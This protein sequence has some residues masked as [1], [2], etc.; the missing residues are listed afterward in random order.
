M[1]CVQL[2]PC[3]HT[4]CETC[5]PKWYFKAGKGQKKGTCITCRQV[6]AF[7]DVVRAPAAK[8]RQD[9]DY[10]DDTKFAQV[11]HHAGDIASHAHATLQ[12]SDRLALR[13]GCSGLRR[14]Q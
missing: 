12:V 5:Y 10:R 11:S 4:V 3:G 6:F 8:Q 1:T 9:A 7:S 14:L 13:T 2:P